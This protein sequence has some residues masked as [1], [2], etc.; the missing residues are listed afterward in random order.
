MGRRCTGTY[1][2]GRNSRRHLFKPA[3]LAL[4]VASCFVPIA[5]LANPTNPAVVSGTATFQQSGNLLSI[6]NSPSA[7]INWGSFSIGAGEITRFIQQSQASAV[8]NRVVGQDPSAILGA[9]Q[10]NGRVFLINPNGILFGAAAQIDVAGLVASTLNLSDADFLAGR[11]RFSETLNAGGV[12]NQGGISTTSGGSVY[13]VAPDITNSGIITSP[14]G[15]VVLAAGRSVELVDPGTPNL[16]VEISAPDTQA[17]NLGQI[18]A[19]AGRVGIYAGLINHSGTIQANS[20]VVG[21]RGEIMLRATQNATLEAGSVTTASGPQGGSVTIQS[22][23]TTLVSGTVEA[24]GVQGQGGAV[25]ILGNL[26]GLTDSASLDAS[27]E[28][29][30]GTVL[31][32]GDYQGRNLEVQ[33]AYRT[34]FGPEASIKADAIT[35]GDG[36]KVI[37]WADDVTR[38]YGSIS[39]RGGSQSGNGGFVEVSG[40]NWLDFGAI[41]DTRAPYGA[42]GT[43]LLDP[44]DVTISNAA[45]NL[46]GGVFTGNV[47]A[48]A[49]S[50]LT[51]I[52]WSTI[53][54]QLLLGNVIITT[55]GI[56]G[57]GNITVADAYAYTRASNLSLLAHN[58]ITLNGAI[59][60]SGTGG[61]SMY[62]GWDG[63]A[64]SPGIAGSGQISLNAPLT[65]NGDVFL[66]AG[67]DITQLSTAAITASRLLAVGEHVLLD[68]ADNLVN[69]IAGIAG[70]CC[71]SSFRFRNGQSL[72]IG[73]VGTTS[74]VSASDNDGGSTINI[75]VTSGSLTVNQS[76]TANNPGSDAA[77]TL[78]AAGDVVLNSSVTANG[79]TPTVSVTSTGG[80]ITVGNSAAV[81]ASDTFGN[82]SITFTASSGI[83][84]GSG[85]SLL[86]STTGGSADAT[87]SLT[88]TSGNI[89]TGGNVDANGLGDNSVT[90][91]TNNG[92][93]VGQGGILNVSNGLSSTITLSATSGIGQ[94]G[95]PIRIQNGIPDLV[96]TNSTSGDVVLSQVTGNIDLDVFNIAN[97]AAGKVID[98]TAEAGS[99]FVNTAVS[100]PN[101]GLTLRA[102]GAGSDIV[103]DADLSSAAGSRATLI[104]NDQ[105]TQDGGDITGALSL[106]AGGDVILDST[107]NAINFL[108][109]GSALG[110]QLDVV[111][112]SALTLESV[113]TNG[114]NVTIESSNN[115]VFGAAGSGINAGG[116]TVALTSTGGA[117]VDSHAGTDIVAGAAT[118]SAA[119][120]IASVAAPLQTQ[121]ASLTMGSTSGEIGISNTGNLALAFGAFGGSNLKVQSTG[122]L[123]T[124]G[125]AL[126]ASGSISLVGNGVAIGQGLA[127]AGNFH[128]DAGAGNLSISGSGASGANVL[129]IGNNIDIGNAAAAS[130]TTVSAGNAMTITALGNLT[131]QGGSAAGASAAVDSVAG[132]TTVTTGGNVLVRGG[133]GAGAYGSLVGGPELFMTVGGNVR[134]DVGA[135]AGAYGQIASTSP[136][137][138]QL[139]FPN[140]GVGGYF[141]NGVEYTVYDALSASGFLAGGVPAILGNNLLITYG[142]SAPTSLLPPLVQTTTTLVEGLLQT[143]G[144]LTNTMLQTTGNLLAAGGEILTG[145]EYI[146]VWGIVDNV[147][148]ELVCR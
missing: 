110:G 18:V 127:A 16:R 8:L 20:A 10:S 51:N 144:A 63:N 44:S 11:L 22:G 24:R 64:L 35:A 26:V 46:F 9:L 1:R 86:A 142:L 136:N 93:I 90:L 55:T 108:T 118:I 52:A 84:I 131:V 76:V 15:E 71:N 73:T 117:I 54:T 146:G 132:N 100:N 43:L 119:S 85:S 41:V 56:G 80:G 143:T 101:G 103:M 66:H 75:E 139:H 13:L 82:A 23:D 147:R 116:G 42:A 123:T 27:G 91:T 47:F 62:A 112:T 135:G 39:A 72:V 122:A 6:A 111:T 33:N 69:E 107:T 96:V 137:S 140:L 134:M 3:A 92:A 109:T 121:L 104:A 138:I 70:T 77:V 45:D 94:L 78:S 37:V 5:V 126:N 95:N 12:V 74:G 79:A 53:D 36:G 17:R 114:G 19:D 61:I 14:G 87:V 28:T 60:N 133:S 2:D 32:G 50:S 97:N 48:G 81:I 21:E 4:A 88:T 113:A 38:A 98:L 58:D 67:G 89:T 57:S 34:Y 59:S 120:G 68:Q 115:I 124:S 83:T 25:K 141:V 65:M 148:N 29:G 7:I 145:G 129:L 30:G 125:A 99:I 106:S 49:T 102:N 31:V 130:P 128:L 40:K 105:I